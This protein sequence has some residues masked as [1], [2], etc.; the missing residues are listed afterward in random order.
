VDL[1]YFL[2]SDTPDFKDLPWQS[3]IDDWSNLTN[4]LV[5]VESGL[6]RHPIVFVNYEG[7]I[8]AIKELPSGIAQKEFNNLLAINKLRLPSVVVV[9]YGEHKVA[10]SSST[11]LIT[12]YLE[13]SIPYLSIFQRSS[14]DRYRNSIL[15][16][17]AGL[18][19]QL[20]LNGIYWGDCSLSNILFRRDAGTLQAYLVDAE[21]VELHDPPLRPTDR[22][23]DLEIMQ[24][25]IQND[26][27]YSN[28]SSLIE[29]YPHSDMGDYIR[30]RYQALWEEITREIIVKPGEQYRIQ[31]R[32][33]S[34]HQLGFSIKDIEILKDRSGDKLRLRVILTDRNFH[35]DRL[36]ELTGIVAEDM[37]A[38]QMMN[39]IQQLRASISQQ[40]DSSIPLSV[41]AHNWLKNIYEPVVNEL[42]PILDKKGISYAL[43]DLPEIYCQ[44]LENKWYLSEKAHRD[45]GHH[46]AVEDYVNRFLTK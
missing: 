43:N 1:E 21:T 29:E 19:V 37:Q 8:Y 38:R 30:T 28:I 22:H 16:A 44:I 6:S 32:I 36:F 13:S 41:A 31:D 34:L 12:K 39:E 2:L 17:M 40:T 24:E 45:I 10:D 3:P 46:S 5:R 42:K 18:L 26:L 11:L 7:S 23:Q 9:G 25:N 35:R 27:L 33:N 15:D 4:R 20:H 14:M